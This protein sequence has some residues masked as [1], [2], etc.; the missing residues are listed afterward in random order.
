M[1]KLWS[2][3]KFEYLRRVKTK[4]FI[5]AVIS[6]P[7]IIILAM[8]LG[9]VSVKMQTDSRP[10][11]YS[12]PS[13]IFEI[14]PI[15]A[16]PN[17]SLIGKIDMIYYENTESGKQALEIQ[18]I[19]ALFV[20]GE[21]YL[22]TGRIT[23]FA[24]QRPGENAYTRMSDFLQACLISG[25]N[26]MVQD[27]IQNGNNYTVKSLDGSR[28]ANMRDWFVVL[29]PFLSGLIF[30][31]V[32]NISGGYLLQSVVDEKENRTME[33]VVTSVSPEQ[34]MYGKIIGNLCV[35]LS[36]LFIWLL[37]AG[38]GL[39]GIQLIFHYGQAPAILPIHIA[40]IFGIIL[41]GFILIAALMTLVGVTATEMREAQQ[42]SVLFTLPM[43]APYWFAGAVLQHP[44]NILTTIM[45]IFPFTSIVTMPL[46]IS[47]ASVPAWQFI[48]AVILMWFS[49]IGALLLAGKAFRLGMLQY[50]K[51]ISLKN[52]FR[53]IEKNHA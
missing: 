39:L 45:S 52:V 38:V 20:I 31:I 49:A 17:S 30:I 14:M 13:G 36:Q 18:E 1:K 25:E 53:S 23:V 26:E 24:N 4:G 2:I 10:I 27:R 29:F 8:V 34:L 28:Q 40:L 35:G 9:I 3:F 11:G 43:V 21:D 44:E 5:F 6:M 16:D 51:R 15:P 50:G 37:F 47:I 42:V 32:I 33:M 46:R 48:A 41:P 19:Q 7:L 22:D 12:D